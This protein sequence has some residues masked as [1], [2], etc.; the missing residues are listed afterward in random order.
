MAPLESLNTIV[1]WWT[2]G[3]R[4]FNWAPVIPVH[5]SLSDS[6]T[7]GRGCFPSLLGEV[8]LRN[9]P[10]SPNFE[11]NNRTGKCRPF[12]TGTRVLAHNGGHL[13][14]SEQFFRNVRGVSGAFNWIPMLTR[15][16]SLSGGCTPG[17]HINSRRVWWA[18]ELLA[19]TGK[20][21]DW[22]NNSDQT[23]SSPR[24]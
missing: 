22:K 12:E 4:A 10:Q 9:T 3:F 5:V 8:C 23:Y 18:H 19:K 20:L 15:A 13:H 17:W 1:L 6:F 7:S 14:L 11:F 2:G 16:V 21:P 24:G